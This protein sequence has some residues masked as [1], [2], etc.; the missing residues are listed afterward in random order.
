MSKRLKNSICIYLFVSPEVHVKSIAYANVYW[1]R[2]NESAIIKKINTFK[3]LQR[4]SSL[5]Y[6]QWLRMPMRRHEKDQ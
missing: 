6:G 5:D 3:F 2:Y 1:V 4:N